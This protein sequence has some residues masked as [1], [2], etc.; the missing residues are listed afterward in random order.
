MP[1]AFIRDGAI[2]LTKTSIILEE[3]SFYGKRIG[4]SISDK[5]RHVNIDTMQDWEKA[6]AIANSLP[7]K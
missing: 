1:K 3:D 4:Y 2:Y 5:K 6:E 7:I